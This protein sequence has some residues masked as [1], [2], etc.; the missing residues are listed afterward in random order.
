VLVVL[1]A[2]TWR[3]N[4]VYAESE[5]LWRDNV[6]KNPHSWAAFNNLGTTLW[7]LRRTQEAIGCWE[8]ALLIKPNY[9][10]VHNNLASPLAQAGKFDEAIEHYKQ[11][12][13]LRPEFS[14]AST[15]LARLRPVPVDR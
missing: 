1:G 7:Q 12:L 14:V 4:S 15:A 3:R 10:E 13:R 2:A 9:P 6:A 8:Q 5:T 11:A